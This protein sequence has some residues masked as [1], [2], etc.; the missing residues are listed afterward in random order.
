MTWTK[1]PTPLPP[2]K[3]TTAAPTT[4]TGARARFCVSVLGMV[5]CFRKFVVLLRRFPWLV[6][7]RLRSKRVEMVLEA[8]S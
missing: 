4:T 5:A 3:R 6:Q 1:A 2:W 7:L 8:G